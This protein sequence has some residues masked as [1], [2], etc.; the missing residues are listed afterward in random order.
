M[1]RTSGPGAP[2]AMATLRPGTARHQAGDPRR[3]GGGVE[4]AVGG[5]GF[6]AAGL[7][8]EDRPAV[9][10][11][12]QRPRQRR[13]L[14]FVAAVHGSL[15]PG[16]AGRAALWPQRVVS[17]MSCSAMAGTIRAWNS[18]WAETTAGVRPGC[19]Y[20]TRPQLGEQVEP[21]QAQRV[22]FP[23]WS[24]G[25]GE[26]PVAGPV[27]LGDPA[28]E[29][30]QRV[31]A[32]LAVQLPPP[33]RRHWPVAVPV[34][35]VRIRVAGRA[36]EAGEQFR[37]L[38][39]LPGGLLV[40]AGLA[41]VEPA[42]AGRRGRRAAAGPRSSHRLAPGGRSRDAPREGGAGRERVGRQLAAARDAPRVTGSAGSAAAVPG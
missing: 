28:A 17:I 35:G 36:A 1:S 19:R 2:V 29:P 41:C 16:R 25:G 40:V 27:H 21:V 7:A 24:E 23:A 15:P 37:E 6:L 34:L 39:Q 4:V 33:R 9:P 3:V 31:L 42:R 18:A 14:W 30:V 26:L 10:G 11:V 22:L 12:G 38:G 8:G 13:V 20:S 32:V 5:G